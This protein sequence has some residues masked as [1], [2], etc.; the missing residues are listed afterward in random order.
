MTPPPSAAV[1][2]IAALSFIGLASDPRV[3]R[4]LMISNE[5]NKVFA[6]RIC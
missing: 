4:G 6:A 5:R 3:L 2:D 1:L